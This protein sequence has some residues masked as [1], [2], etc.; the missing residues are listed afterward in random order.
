MLRPVD[1]F[2]GGNRADHPVDEKV[3][4]AS[5]STR[6]FVVEVDGR[7]GGTCCREEKADGP[8]IPEHVVNYPPVQPHVEQRGVSS[9]NGASPSSSGTDG[10]KNRGVDV[11]CLHASIRPFVHSQKRPKADR[12]S[13]SRKRIRGYAA[14]GDWR[15]RF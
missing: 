8:K 15:S 4:V 10:W 9:M 2:D 7:G 12:R 3:R 11:F 1:G 14:S 5:P 6:V 13:K